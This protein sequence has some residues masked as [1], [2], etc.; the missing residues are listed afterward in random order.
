MDALLQTSGPEHDGQQYV[1][2]FAQVTYET[3]QKCYPVVLLLAFIISA[4]IHSIA[5]SRTEEELLIPTATGPGGK[6]LPITKRKREHRDQQSLYSTDG[7][8]GGIS[9]QVFRCLVGALIL[10]FAANAAATALHVWQSSKVGGELWW[11]GEERVVYV[12][13]AAF[14]YIYVLITLFD[15]DDSPTPVHSIIWV[16]G[17][18]GEAIILLSFVCTL[19]TGKYVLDG[20][21]MGALRENPL[22]FWDLTDLGIGGVRLLIVVFLVSMYA[23]VASKRRLEE[24]RLLDEEANRSDSDETSPLLSHSGTATPYNRGRSRQNSDYGGTRNVN[25]NANNDPEGGYQQCEDNAAFYRPDKLPHKTW[26]EYCRGYSIFFPY[27]WPSNSTKLKLIVL[28][29]FLLEVSQRVVNI[30]VPEQIKTVTDTLAK[31]FDHPNTGTGAKIA[32][33]LTGIF[34]FSGG[35]DNGENPGNTGAPWFDLGLFIALKLLQGPSGLLGSARSILWIPVSQHTY[36]AL[37]TAAFEH[38]H[39]LS[40]DFHLGKRTGEVLSALNKGA[41]INQFLEQVTFQ[42]VPMLVDLLLAIG[43]FYFR[44]GAMYALFVSIITFYYLYL[45]IRMAATRSDQRRDMV[46]ADREEEAVKNDSITSYETVKYF[47]AEQHEFARYRNAI[48]NFQTAEAKVTW[49]INHM[50]MCQSIVFMCGLLVVLLTCGYEVS[51]GTRTVGEFTSLVTYLAQLQG[52]LNFFGSFYRTIQQAMISGERL[53]ELFKIQPTV[54]DSPGAVPLQ[55]STGHIKWENVG[56]S[57]DNRRTAL[58]DLSFECKPGTTT[59]FVGES[60]GGKSTVFRLMFRYYNPKAGRLLI[61]GQDVQDLTIDSVRR[62]IGVV[63]QDTI[64]FNETLMYNLRYANP[65]ASDEEIYEACRAAAIHDRIMSFPDGYNTKVGE[66]GLRLSGGEKQRVAI[67][68][69]ILKNPKIIM[70]DEATSALDGETEQKIQSKLISGKFGQG[71]TLLIIAHRLSTITH[72]DQIIVLHAGTMVEKGTHEELL[73][74]NGRYAAMWEKHCRAERAAEHARDATR[75]AKKLM[76]Y[77][78][79][80]RPSGA[81]GYDSMLSSAILPTAMNSPTLAPKHD[82]SRSISSNDS[83]HSGSGSDGTLQEEDDEQPEK[84]QPNG[85]KQD[86]ERRPLL[87]SFPSGTTAGRSTD[88]PDRV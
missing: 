87:Y 4:G 41:S 55:E 86:E 68:R 52:P 83:H 78:N 21:E 20:E 82:D 25:K 46:N 31:N 48:V 70:L 42:V 18:F 24:R 51:Q 75:K 23:L 58:H 49:G 45:T 59:A 19:A 74:L 27:L 28:L 81:N 26:F 67:A 11:C 80:S 15:W 3:T 6:P 65:S 73:A 88:A 53:L 9:I 35:E 64:L 84:L 60:G 43:W 71:R 10:S 2:A 17:L 29:C 32:A 44:Y 72:A 37:T 66:R 61:E 50:N 57:Y 7:C 13:G 34:S 22:G 14:L 63:P 40:L 16:L 47:N 56:F 77:A 33:G 5:K 12:V 85:V 69:T 62:A 76:G 1:K 39:S 30:M 54:V 8:N 36:R 79:I 38:V